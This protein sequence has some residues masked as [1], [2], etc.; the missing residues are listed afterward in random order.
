M[1]FCPGGI[2]GAGE[3]KNGIATEA[4]FDWNP[5]KLHKLDDG[6]ATSCTLDR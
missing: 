6:P 3:K 1:Y 5:Y 4:T 2:F